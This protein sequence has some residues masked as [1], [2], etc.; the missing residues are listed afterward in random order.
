[1]T[2]EADRQPNAL[3]ALPVP[4]AVLAWLYIGLAMAGLIAGG[5]F[6]LQVWQTSGWLGDTLL[7]FAIPIFT[8][9]SMVVFLPALVG[10]IGLLRGKTWARIV[11][12]LLSIVMIFVFP[13]GTI[14]GDLASW[15]CAPNR[16]R[17]ARRPLSA[18]RRATGLRALSLS[19]VAP[20]W[21]SRALAPSAPSSCDG[22]FGSA[23]TFRP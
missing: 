4:I 9:L 1:M 11:I 7:A 23:R 5:S 8:F 14:L 17:P 15:H 13:I 16:L 21:G 2:V 22:C 6:C 20:F 19:Y 10:G 12:F 18:C 3:Q